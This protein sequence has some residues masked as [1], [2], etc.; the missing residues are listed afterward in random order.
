MLEGERALL[1]PRIFDLLHQIKYQFIDFGVLL[2]AADSSAQ[3]GTDSRQ[4]PAL[5]RWFG[6]ERSTSVTEAFQKLDDS[7]QELVQIVQVRLGTAD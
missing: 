5:V 6:K 7:Y 3:A 1:P 4:N 2:E